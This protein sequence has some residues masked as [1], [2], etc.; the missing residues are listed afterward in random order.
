M[1]SIANRM[2]E[3][4][5]SRW[6]DWHYW[7]WFFLLWKDY[8]LGALWLV[9]MTLLSTVVA[10]IS[11]LFF[12]YLIDSLRLSLGTTSGV[13]D[14]GLRWHFLFL[15][16]GIGVAQMA[17]G[18]YPY[19]R[20]RMN[21]IFEKVLRRKYFAALLCRDQEFLSRFRTGDLVTRLTDDLSRFPKTSWFACSGLF[22]ALNS[23]CVVI[24]CILAMMS[25]HVSLSLLCLAPLPIAIMIYIRISSR[26]KDAYQQN[27]S[28]ISQTNDQL[29]AS[30]SGIRVL[31]AYN[32]QSGEISRFSDILSTRFD[33]EMGVVKLSGRLEVFYEFLA[34]A[35]QILVVLVGGILVI[36]GELSLGNYYAFFAYLGMIGYPMMDIPH[37]FVSS[38]Q[39]FA[40]VDRLDEL[41]EEESD[42]QSDSGIVLKS[43]QSFQSLEMRDVSFRYPA[44]V[45]DESEALHKINLQLKAGEHIAIVGEIGSGKTTLLQ[46]IAGVFEPT[47]G[48]ILLNGHPLPAHSLQSYQSAIGYVTQE[49][50]VFS[51]TVLENIRFWRDLPD[52]TVK[53]AAALSQMKSEIAAMPEMYEEEIGQRGITLSGGQ[54]QR[55][56]IARAAAGSPS[57]LLMDDVTAALDSENEEAFWD[58]IEA[59]LSNITVVLVTH[60]LS[61]A[62]RADRLLVMEGGKIESEGT[63]E[64][65][66]V[67]SEAFKRLIRKEREAH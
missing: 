24:A 54:K 67:K 9:F 41:K 40:C 56:T 14:E 51:Q 3:S 31:K 5:A 43:A 53:W 18:W 30:I 46:L 25:L 11:P 52:E 59:E 47:G 17:A 26:L 35:S 65:L 22:R 39:A 15:L 13:V 6:K 23:V 34:H 1:N 28:Q 50:L 48:E 37:L 21:L 45:G 27:Q 4:L 57:L 49:P 58:S 20:A 66:M 42:T 19:F 10:V 64:E 38:R 29:E 61:S 60:R 62:R 44:A 55:L 12:A 63:L 7:R 8:P 2:D 16:L 32:A 36:Q 33:V